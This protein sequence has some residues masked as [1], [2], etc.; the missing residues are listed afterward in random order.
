MLPL[1]PKM[2]ENTATS[3]ESFKERLH[4]Y[5]AAVRST[6]E[7]ISAA[8]LIT[9]LD[10]AQTQAAQP[11]PSPQRPEPTMAD[12]I[13]A[14]RRRAAEGQ[15]ALRRPPPQL[16][17][18]RAPE[19]DASR[20]SAACLP[21][22]ARGPGGGKEPVPSA[23]GQT[24]RVSQLPRG[25]REAEAPTP[26]NASPC[27]SVN[28][29]LRASMR[30]RASARAAAAGDAATSAGAEGGCVNGGGEMRTARESRRIRIDVSD[31]GSDSDSD[32]DDAEPSIMDGACRYA[33]LR[34]SSRAGE[35]SRCRYL[36]SPA[37]TRRYLEELRE[38]SR[39]GFNAER[40]L[41]TRARQHDGPELAAAIAMW[42][43]VH[44]RHPQVCSQ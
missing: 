13:I 35:P 37:V 41:A 21:A 4:H 28:A 3:A 27:T 26:A 39:A 8:D 1:S 36:P 42:E 38:P 24:G 15:R 18:E 19:H 30:E 32:A 29:S 2:I 23:G 22:A 5:N 12:K 16:H 33:E 9:S 34:E 25:G 7:G 14:Q 17:R 11:L 43:G 6:E 40:E 10:V 31:S 44:D 20:G